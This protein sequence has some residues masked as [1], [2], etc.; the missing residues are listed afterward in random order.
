MTAS[1]PVISFYQSAAFVPTCHKVVARTLN[2]ER[3]H[4]SEHAQG[5]MAHLTAYFDE[6]TFER[7]G[8]L[9]GE[10][11]LIN[12]LLLLRRDGA[13][14]KANMACEDYWAA[15]AIDDQCASDAFRAYARGVLRSWDRLPVIENAPILTHPYVDNYYHWTLEAVPS[16]RLFGSPQTNRIVLP[17]PAKLR[18]QLD[19]VKR[20]A[21]GWEIVTV[22]EPVV[23]RNPIV[24]C[25]AMSEEGVHWL[26][27]TAGISV[28]SGDRRIYLKRSRKTTRGGPSGGLSETAEVIA[29]LKEKNFEIVD[30]G[31]GELGIAEQAQMLAGA[32]V[33]LAPHGA[34]LTNLVYLSPPLSLIE[35]IGTATPRAMFMHI[36]SMLHFDYHAVFNDSYDGEQDLVINVADLREA[37]ERCQAARH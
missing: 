23:I 35:V 27:R 9:H 17:L 3:V 15:I 1:Q 8:I 22:G 7:A 30:F 18:F 4:C 24:S 36:A 29:F 19:L 37:F 5:R 28:A 14:V 11:A 25:A 34:A 32:G 31:D 16:I 2:N 13:L 10:Y 21:R 12:G 20:A 6:V 33:I 26:R